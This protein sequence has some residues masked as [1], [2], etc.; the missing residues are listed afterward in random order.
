ML[1]WLIKRI[2]AIYE[3]KEPLKVN[4]DY[5]KE[6]Y[7]ALANAGDDVA[8]AFIVIRAIY[9]ASHTRYSLFHE[10]EEFLYLLAECI[11]ERHQEIKYYV[12][13]EALIEDEYEINMVALKCAE[14]LYVPRQK[15]HII[16]AIK[17]VMLVRYENIKSVKEAC[18]AAIEKLSTI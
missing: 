7:L 17:N 2:R 16:D 4:A 14:S 9:G 13:K 1:D 11:S 5:V 10:R 18:E 3:F 15:T 12:T 6:H 8:F